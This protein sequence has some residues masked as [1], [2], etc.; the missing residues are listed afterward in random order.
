MDL[1]NTDRARQQ[2]GKKMS[3]HPNRTRGQTGSNSSSRNPTPTEV[4]AAREAAALTQAAAAAVI[5]CTLNTW[6]KWESGDSR[7][8]PAFWELFKIKAGLSNP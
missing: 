7:M 5:H 4:K 1:G 3:N 8:H 6:Q 2:K